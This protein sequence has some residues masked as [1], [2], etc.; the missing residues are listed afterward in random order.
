MVHSLI[1]FF[2]VNSLALFGE[3][4]FLTACAVVGIPMIFRELPREEE[5]R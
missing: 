2:A 1:F 4:W 3:M 5:L